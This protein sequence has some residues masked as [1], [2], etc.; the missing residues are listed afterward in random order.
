MRYE[1]Y[2]AT[3]NFGALLNVGAAYSRAAAFRLV[4]NEINSVVYPRFVILET[5]RKNAV[6]I[7][8]ESGMTEEGYSTV[9]RATYVYNG[10]PPGKSVVIEQAYLKGLMKI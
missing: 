8:V 10:Y 3:K 9:T 5:P 6:P 4:D 1:V 2:G 7:G